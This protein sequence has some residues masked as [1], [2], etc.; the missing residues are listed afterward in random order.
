MEQTEILEA[1]K[2]IAEF[3]GITF[4]L[5]HS[6]QAVFIRY[7]T[8]DCVTQFGTVSDAVNRPDIRYHSS[9]DLIMEVCKKFDTLEDRFIDRITYELHC[10]AI[11]AAVTCYEIE[12]VF[13]A[14]TEAI[15]WY[16][17]LKY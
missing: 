6:G 17:S 3:D 15:K 4:E 11:D 2:I 8:G 12:P 16:N 10:D 13:K 7:K 14:L 1:D 5:V 9:W